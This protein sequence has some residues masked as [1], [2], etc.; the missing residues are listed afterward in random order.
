ME[1]G[2]GAAQFGMDYGIANAQ[3]RPSGE[4][5]RRI[6]AVAVEKGVRVIDTAAAY[7]ESE[8]ALGRHLRYFGRCRFRV[9]TKTVPLSLARGTD[10]APGRIREGVTRSLERLGL[11]QVDGLLV[12]QAS[13]LLDPGGESVWAVLEALRDQGLVGRIGFSAYTGADIDAA[14]ERFN[15]DLIQVPAN[16]LDQRLL[17]GGQLSR[18]AARGV[19][20]HVRS[21]FLQ[22]LLL[23]D[24]EH[25]PAYFDPIRNSLVG[26]RH[27]LASRGIT[28]AQGA[29]AFARTLPA[30]TILVGVESATQLSGNVA[31]FAL[32]GAQCLDFSTYALDDE[33][34]VNPAKWKL[35]A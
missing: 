21:V 25:V 16:I 14:M 6:L 5:I 20:V 33:Q 3:G 2:I 15:F 30:A 24:P 19:E 27:A 18:L 32:A 29:L 8:L 26:L 9:V 13:D 28:P 4:E 23:M 31:D 1:L 35:A 7:G 34:Y 10:D 17:H 22:G 12:H 11:K